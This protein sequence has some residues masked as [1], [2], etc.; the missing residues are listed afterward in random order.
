MDRNL[1]VMINFR[2]QSD[3]A[4]EALKFAHENELTRAAMIRLAIKKYI[5]YSKK[6][7]IQRDANQMKKVL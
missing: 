4:Q 2:C 1:G 5:G 3:L 7:S 6:N